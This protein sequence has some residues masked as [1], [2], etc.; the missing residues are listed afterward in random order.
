MLSLKNLLCLAVAASAA[1]LP[2]SIVGIESDL[3]KVNN[4]IITLTNDIELGPFNS[5]AIA[6]DVD[7]LHGEIGTATSDAQV[8]AQL[9]PAEAEAVLNYSIPEVF[10]STQAALAALNDRKVEYLTALL[11]PI[12]LNDLRT[13]RLDAADYVQ[14]L[15]GLSPATAAGFERYG[16]A[17]DSAFQRTI[18]NF[19][20]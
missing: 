17:L 19:S 8:S 7:N 15:A 12:I 2:R 4:L 1:V 11:G 20:N 3:A 14:A 13:L 6:I 16:N 9:S 18:Y 5:I 10:Q